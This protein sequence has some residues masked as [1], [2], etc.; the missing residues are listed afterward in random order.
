MSDFGKDLLAAMNEAAEHA[1]GEDNGTIIHRIG[2][3]DVNPTYIR[4]KLGFTQEVMAGLLGTSPSGYRKWEQGL[5]KPS[6]SALTLLR[7]MDVE[8]E[9]VM[10][11]LRG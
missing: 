8:P 3:H 2:T 6:G 9:A 5:R 4:K 11:A 7:V 10:R 1:S